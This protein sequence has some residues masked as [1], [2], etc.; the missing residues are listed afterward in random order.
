MFDSTPLS[1]T[2]TSLAYLSDYADYQARRGGAVLPQ[3]SLDGN[4]DYVAT[5]AGETRVLASYRSVMTGGEEGTWHSQAHDGTWTAADSRGEALLAGIDEAKKLFL[6]WASQLIDALP[7]LCGSRTLNRTYTYNGPLNAVAQNQF[8]VPASASAAA[9][10]DLT[11]YPE[12]QIGNFGFASGLYTVVSVDDSADPH[13]ITVQES[14]PA[15]GFSAEASLSYRYESGLSLPRGDSA[16]RVPRNIRH[17]TCALARALMQ[18]PTMFASRHDAT[19]VVKSVEVFKAV[20]VG[21]AASDDTLAKQQR[22]YLSDEVLSLLEPSLCSPIR[23]FCATKA[24]TT[25]G[26]SVIKLQRDYLV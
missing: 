9:W 10:L 21:F 2:A 16:M 19:G 20:K 12:V 11:E 24:G 23:G 3:A 18:E 25:S 1:P 22:P 7:E 13:I 17:A 5:L 14:V 6:N 15:D 26:F 8:T 4:G